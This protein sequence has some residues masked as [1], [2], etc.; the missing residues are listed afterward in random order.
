LETFLNIANLN[1]FCKGGGIEL[2]VHNNRSE[3]NAFKTKLFKTYL[4]SKYYDKLLLSNT[5]FE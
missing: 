3:C 1:T 2:F 4:F 5:S